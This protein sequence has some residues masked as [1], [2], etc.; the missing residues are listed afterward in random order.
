NLRRCVMSRKKLT[1]WK[2]GALMNSKRR[3]LLL[4]ISAAAACIASCSNIKYLPEGENLYVKGKVEI[5]TDTIPERYIEPLSTNLEELLRH[6]PNKKLL[7]MRPQLYIYNIAGEPEKD[8]GLRHWLRTK[9]GE[10]PVL[11]SDVNREYNENL[12]RNRLENLGFFQA[13]V[14]SDTTID[15]RKATVTYTASPHIIYRINSVTFEVDSSELGRAIKATQ[16]ASLLQV[17]R[18]YN[19]DNIIAERERIDNE[20]K[21]QGY[22]YFSPDHLIVE[23]DSVGG[24]H[25]VDLYLKVKDEAPQRAK[26][27][28][29]INDI[30]I[31]PNYRLDRKS[32]V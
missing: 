27:P 21:N 13:E 29:T 26:R 32:V 2:K 6:K 4:C 8:K 1:T 3:I 11:L 24:D 23:V 22:Y 20:L 12:L 25:Q 14:S 18:P 7:G 31:Y 19:L 17:G 28:Y 10:P 30:F 15:N 9:V 5:D 16:P